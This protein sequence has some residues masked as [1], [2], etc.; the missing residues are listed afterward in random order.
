MVGATVVIGAVDRAVV[1]SLVDGCMANLKIDIA[2]FERMKGELESRHLHAWVLFHHGQFVDA[3]P[4]FEAAAAMAVDRF[5]E[6][7]YLIRQV[8][9]GAIQLAGGMVFRPS[10]ALDSS[11]L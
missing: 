10:H 3:F 6:G 1:K 8:G 11:G 9:A 4:D 2:A 5:N 7:P